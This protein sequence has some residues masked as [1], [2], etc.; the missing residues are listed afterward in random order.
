MQYLLDPRSGQIRGKCDAGYDFDGKEYYP[1]GY[2][3]TYYAWRYKSFTEMPTL[4]VEGRQFYIDFANYATPPY[5]YL[6]KEDWVNAEDFTGL[7]PVDYDEL[8]TE[9]KPFITVEQMGPLFGIYDEASDLIKPT[10]IL[11]PE[12]CWRDGAKLLN[13]AIRLQAFLSGR[14]NGFDLDDSV[15][16]ILHDG[17]GDKS[18]WECLSFYPHGLRS[19]YKE[20]LELSEEE[21][22]RMFI[23]ARETTIEGM[24]VLTSWKPKSPTKWNSP[25]LSVSLIPDGMSTT[26]LPSAYV[27]VKYMLQ[28]SETVPVVRV[29]FAHLLRALV[30]LHTHR[31]Y[32]DLHDG[33]YGVAYNNLLER[34]WH[35]FANDAALGKLGVCELCGEVFEAM[36]ERKDVKRF[37][38]VSCQENAKS[39]RQYRRK[40]IRK[41]IEYECTNDVLYLLHVLDDPEITREMVEEALADIAKASNE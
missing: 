11:E 2:E 36:S 15:Y 17:A 35:D 22:Q 28:H 5:S 27:S 29:L 8:F 30:R 33:F 25:D 10:K 31:I 12:N 24:T 39:A 4:A 34:L 3:N 7:L 32:F 26:T 41:V 23:P 40:K 19:P 13:V 20:M 1:S 16:F 37:C 9:C 6:L 38:S 14:S 21:Q 18:Y